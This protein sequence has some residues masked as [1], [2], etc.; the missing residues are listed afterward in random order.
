MLVKIEDIKV[1]KRVRRDLGDLTALK[2]S[3]HRYGLMNPIT[4]N[5]N[6]EL[7]AGER[8]LEAAKSLGWERINAN[9]LDSNVDNIRQLEM[10][11][12]ENNQRKEF[13]DEELMEGY[14]RLEKLKNPPLIMRILKFIANIF[15]KIA[16]FIKSLFGKK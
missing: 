10:E 15:I 7:V 13:T 9:I 16:E 5:S 2:D 11:L 14:K 12:E 8:R 6:Y 3:M 4:L 1:K